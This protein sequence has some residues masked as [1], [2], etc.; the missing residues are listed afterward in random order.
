MKK[1]L[2]ISFIVVLSTL[3]CTSMNDR[4][5]NIKPVKPIKP[6]EKEDDG[7]KPTKP[8]SPIEKV[9]EDK[10]ENTINDKFKQGKVDRKDNEEKE[11]NVEKKPNNILVGDDTSLEKLKVNDLN[12]SKYKGTMINSISSDYN[13]NSLSK[14]KLLNGEYKKSDKNIKEVA[15]VEISLT[16]E[17]EKKLREFGDNITFSRKYVENFNDEK[18][19]NHPYYTIASFVDSNRNH[20]I[21]DEKSNIKI[22]VYPMIDFKDYYK[23]EG[24]INM[25][26]GSTISDLLLGTIYSNGKY[27][28]K[29]GRS[30]SNSVTIYGSNLASFKD[31]LYNKQL[32]VIV[33][34]NFSDTRKFKYNIKNSYFTKD[35]MQYFLAMSPEKQMMYR[36]DVITVRNVIEKNNQFNKNNG[37]KIYDSDKK[38]YFTITKNKDASSL[39]LR[40]MSVADTG[41]ILKPNNKEEIGVS[42]AAPRV[43]RLAYDIKQKFPFLQWNQIKQIILTTAD[44]KKGNNEYLDNEVGWGVVDYEKALKGPS[45]FNAG[46]IDEQRFYAGM[47]SRIYDLDENGNILNRYFYVD[48]DDGESAIFEND[49]VSGLKGKGED[50]FDDL[51]VIKGTNNTKSDTDLYRFRIPKILDSEKAYYA[52]YATAGLRKDGKGSLILKGKQLYKDNIQILDGKLYIMNDV[53]SKEIQVFKNSNLLLGNKEYKIQVNDIKNEGNISILGNVNMDKLFSSKDS[54]ISINSDSLLE[55]KELNSDINNI[56]IHFSEN[57]EK[58]PINL[59]FEKNSKINLTNVLLN[60]K[61][62]YDGKRYSLSYEPFTTNLDKFKNLKDLTESE[63]RNLPSYDVNRRMF[64]EEYS[65]D[66]YFDYSTRD[67]I[68]MSLLNVS[69]LGVKE[70]AINQLFTDNYNTYISNV[71]EN[72]DDSDII[73]FN[74]EKYSKNNYNIYFSNFINTNFSK[75]KKYNSFDYKSINNIIG[76]GSKNYGIDLQYYNSKILYDKGS[77]FNSSGYGFEL[78]AKYFDIIDSGINLMYIDTDIDRSVGD[79]KINSNLKAIMSDFKISLSKTFKIDVY[80]TLKPSLK[81]NTTL[82]S[83]FNYKSKSL[84]D[85]KLEDNLFIKNKFTLGL[86]H[87]LNINKKIDFIE[88]LEISMYDNIK[89]TLNANLNGVK[90]KTIG[91]NLDRFNVNYTVGLKYDINDKL[92]AMIKA[93]I[94]NRNK[95]GGMLSINYEF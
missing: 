39:L 41:L 46:L 66:E 88:N 16:A 91:K 40:S 6:V 86:E 84:I 60:P 30:L 7:S 51:I 65:K 67:K 18:T 22:K 12:F 23:T 48:I 5:D 15:F 95:I 53:N 50:N 81:I 47:P 72:K 36:S 85:L 32:K 8:V 38:E 55:V 77:I 89:T 14:F 44:R 21:D 94:G 61:I 68:D 92:R 10:K 19:N 27:D 37:I 9:E 82:F 49:I 75:S 79:E 71:F 20:I 54:Q 80:N 93:S 74:L 13:V 33:T 90:F 29:I 11:E 59:I 73:K 45:D 2:F 58:K 64:F 25:S 35:A 69:T 70:D 1:F 87:S 56:S 62:K 63:K 34:G 24:I 78:Y 83:I 31:E 42:F 76:L 4:N 3:S 52:S 17:T 28:D 43:S 57:M 26:I